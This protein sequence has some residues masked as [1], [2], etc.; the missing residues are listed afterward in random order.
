MP[1]ALVV[2]AGG[3]CG[4]SGGARAAVCYWVQ[5][6]GVKTGVCAR[7]EKEE[8]ASV[9]GNLEG[10]LEDGMLLREGGSVDGEGNANCSDCSVR[11]RASRSWLR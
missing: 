2:G 6:S 9:K 7:K 1:W 8:G 5:A 4:R 11:T 3:V 10:R